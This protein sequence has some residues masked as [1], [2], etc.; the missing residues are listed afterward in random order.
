MLIL[1][2]LGAEVELL[3]FLDAVDGEAESAKRE[4]T[5]AWAENIKQVRGDQWRLR[6]SPHFLANVIKNQMRRKVAALTESK[7]QFKVR[8]IRPD[9]DK[10][11]QILY[12]VAKSVFER[13]HTDDVVGRLAQFAFTLG[14]GF[15][16]VPYDPLEDDFSVEFVDPRHVFLD[17]GMPSGSDLQKAQYVRID[18]VLA[19]ADIRRRFVGRGSLVQP[20]ERYS[21]YSE[22]GHSRVLASVLSLMPRLYRPGRPSK[23]GPIPRAEV[24]EYWLRDF[25]LNAEGAL[26]FPGGRRVIRAGQVVLLDEAN[27]YWDGAFDLEMFDWD[28]DFDSPWGWD[29]VQD[30]R[31]LQEAINRFGDSWVRNVL[32]SS[33]FRVIGDMDALDP[34]QWKQ[35]DNQPGLVIRKKPTRDLRYEAPVPDSG[36][37]PNAIEGLIRLCDLLTGNMGERGDRSPAQGSSALEGLQMARQALVRAISRRLESLYE[38]IGHKIISR[39]FQFFTS[40]RILMHQ[41]PNR[42]WVAYTFERQKLLQDDHGNMRPN[43]ERQRM[44]KDFRFLVTP[45]SSLAMTRVQRTMAALQLRSAT[46]V[47]PSVRRI[48]QEADMGDPDELIREGIEE[49]KTL[50]APPPP[51][52]RS[53][54]S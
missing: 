8:A 13:S 27:P 7:P 34:D 15:L 35:L 6:R 41:G 5:G 43:E 22:G 39:T 50:P 2:P 20:D 31:R 9:L 51:K 17:P 45:G 54:R 44:F 21:S 37:I 32:L 33:N 38:R 53:G 47:A 14:C 12:N 52:G 40:D 36:A 23:S 18:S 16:R 3:K 26:L 42:D 49:A 46:G 25:Q 24:R 11:S 28:V 48:L 19:L 29:E 30:L 4:A 1:P 10:T